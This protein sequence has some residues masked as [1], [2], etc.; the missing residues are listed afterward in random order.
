MHDASASSP[1]LSKTVIY[2]RPPTHSDGK[3]GYAPSELP[4]YLRSPPKLWCA[5]RGA[6]HSSV[7]VTLFARLRGWST[8]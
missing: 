3:A 2:T 5:Q 8:L 1:A 4:F 6:P 7:T